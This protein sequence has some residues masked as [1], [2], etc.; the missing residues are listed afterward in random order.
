MFTV[1]SIICAMKTVAQENELYQ[2]VQYATKAPSGHN[3]QP[4][5]FAIEQ[6]TITIT[7]VLA[8]SLPEV[9]PHNRELFISLGCAAEN[10]RIAASH[11]GYTTST[12]VSA[13]GIITIALSKSTGASAD[14]LFEQIPK[15]QTNRSLYDGRAIPQETLD[16]LLDALPATGTHLRTWAVNAPE[17]E[18]LTRAVMD[19][20]TYQMND[21][22]FK[23]ELLSWIRFNKRHSEQTSDGLSYAVMGAPNL[24][25]WITK[26][27]ITLML[28]GKTQNKA[29][30][31]KIA[32]SSHLLLLSTDEDTIPAWIALGGTLQRTLLALTSQDIAN[33]Y[34]NQ[35]CEV[36][37]L[38]EQLR[39]QL[40]S[41]KQYPQILLRI[42][43]AKP[44]PYSKRKPMEEVVRREK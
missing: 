26:P 35:P 15:R 5:Q 24:P 6:D 32:S 33:A 21:K 19:G 34:L 13:E 1:L 36:P 25:R 27:I 43:Y 38:R 9:D 37:E 30:R 17:V 39:N 8:K 16:R 22:G 2:M 20:N 7:P 10:L 23:K 4:W 28:K 14:P 29:D 18:T 41:G 12:A 3:T 31:K 40:L 11:F 44:M 42:G